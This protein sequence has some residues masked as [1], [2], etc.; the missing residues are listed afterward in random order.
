[1]K[2]HVFYALYSKINVF[3]IYGLDHDGWIYSIQPY[4]YKECEWHQDAS[5]ELLA[6]LIGPTGRPVAMRMELEKE[7]NG[8]LTATTSRMR[9]HAPFQP[10]TYICMWVGGGSPT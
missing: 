5:F 3:I 2:K 1:M 6:A 8:C 4:V 7:K 10:T 9:R